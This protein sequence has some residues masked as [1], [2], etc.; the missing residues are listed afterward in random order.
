MSRFV[1]FRLRAKGTEESCSK[2]A[3]VLNQYE[4]HS[5]D[6]FISGSAGTPDSFTVEIRGALRSDIS[7]YMIDVP[8][9]EE[10]LEG[11]SKSLHLEIEVFGSDPGDREFEYYHY[12][13]GVCVQKA[14]LPP[15][16]YSEEDFGEL[17][18]SEEDQEKYDRSENGVFVLRKEYLPD[19]AWAEDEEEMLCNFKI[20]MDE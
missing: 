14:N 18:L 20:D 4:G 19:A 16:L 17:E 12:L 10:S 7:K 8:P 2:F 3:A 11:M 9:Y 13:N 5:A 15:Y 1:M 6:P